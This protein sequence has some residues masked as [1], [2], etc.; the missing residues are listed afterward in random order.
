[1]GQNQPPGRLQDSWRVKVHSGRV[2]F[3]SIKFRKN[4]LTERGRHQSH[5]RN[6]KSGHSWEQTSD[7]YDSINF[8]TA[9]GWLRPD[10]YPKARQHLQQRELQQPGGTRRRGGSIGF[11]L[12]DL[13]GPREPIT[14]LHAR[15]LIKELNIV[16]RSECA[17]VC[18]LSADTI[19]PPPPP[20]ARL[21]LPRGSPCARV[22][23]FCV[24]WNRS[25][26]ET[27]FI[28][29]IWYFFG[30][31]TL[32]WLSFY[33]QLIFGIIIDNFQRLFLLAP[34]VFDNYTAASKS[35]QAI[36]FNWAN[37]TKWNFSP[38]R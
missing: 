7:V 6:N 25:S 8:I 23:G 20:T 9:R 26:E 34:I 2:T 14:R 11:R 3:H 35:L 18:P 12:I 36:S 17:P 38:E 31:F 19:L 28:P 27:L 24:C 16:K 1:M 22:R 32:F 5:Y 10:A 21:R 15:S 29:Q 4:I 33:E 37:C 30:G 13:A